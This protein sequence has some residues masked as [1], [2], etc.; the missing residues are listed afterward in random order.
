[1]KTKK[2]LLSVALLAVCSSV[3]AAADQDITPPLFQFQETVP[4]PISFFTEAINGS[5]PKPEVA[6]DFASKA[7]FSGGQINADAAK[8]ATQCDGL[9]AG[10]TIVETSDHFRLLLVKGKNST[11][12]IDANV[13]TIALAGYYVFHLYS[14]DE[15]TY[16]GTTIRYQIVTKTVPA[17]D[18]KFSVLNKLGTVL[19][20]DLYAY[21]ATKTKWWP[22][23]ADVATKATEMP[24]RTKLDFPAGFD[25]HAIY[26]GIVKYTADPTTPINPI[27]DDGW[28][29]PTG[30]PSSVENGLTDDGSFLAWDKQNIYVNNVQEGSNVSVFSIS[31]QLVKSVQVTSAFMEIPM[32]QGIYIVKFGTKTAKVIL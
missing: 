11:E 24:V 21:Q 5:N 18:V 27:P 28:D 8:A 4:G 1:M 10:C 20:K 17:L 19:K 7:V 15:T 13:A 22:L 26:L 2:L 29:T 23:F 31:G 12:W 25:G 9:N 30:I 16:D 32:E 14:G 6:I 3:F